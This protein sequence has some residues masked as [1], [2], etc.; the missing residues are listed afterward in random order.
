MA[1]LTKNAILVTRRDRAKRTNIWDHKDYK[2]LIRNI[3][4][5]SKIY[6]KNSKISGLYQK[7]NLSNGER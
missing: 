6:K 7:C 5:N 4:K 3:Y 2:S 1:A